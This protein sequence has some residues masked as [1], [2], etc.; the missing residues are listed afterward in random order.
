M[1]E[2]WKKQHWHLIRAFLKTCSGFHME[3][4]ILA[5]TLNNL[6]PD[7]CFDNQKEMWG[8][9]WS[10]CALSRVFKEILIEY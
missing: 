5:V 7:S 6:I 9:F 2:V 1:K 8:Y 10:L 4:T 3:K